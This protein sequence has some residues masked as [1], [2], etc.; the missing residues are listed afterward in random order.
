MNVHDMELIVSSRIRTSFSHFFDEFGQ[1]LVFSG[2]VSIVFAFMGQLAVCAVFDPVIGK[3]EISA[4][5]IS[6]GVQWTVA[7]QA[8]EILRVSSFVTWKVFTFSVAEKGIMFPLPIRF[9]HKIRTSVI[10]SVLIISH[11]PLFIKMQ[12]NPFT[13]LKKTKK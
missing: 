7:E 11:F 13:F 9:F 3:L 6:Q 12:Q 5:F 10:F 1:F 4:A 8:V 2:H